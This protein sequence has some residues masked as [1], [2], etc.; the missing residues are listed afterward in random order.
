[1]A[2]LGGAQVTVLACHPR[3]FASEAGAERAEEGGRGMGTASL[4]GM[5]EGMVDLELLL[6]S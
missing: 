1:M 3:G 2:S 6:R 4:G 5:M